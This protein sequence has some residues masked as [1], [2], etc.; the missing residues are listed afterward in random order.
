ME[1]IATLIGSIV[2]AIFLG[3]AGAATAYLKQRFDLDPDGQVLHSLE[4][5]EEKAAGWVMDEAESRGADLTIPETRYSF[6]DDSIDWL[7]PKIPKIMKYMGYSRED[8]MHDVEGLVR[9]AVERGN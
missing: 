5:W 7:V 1:A 3:L 6:V 8:L 2:A 4:N 9:R